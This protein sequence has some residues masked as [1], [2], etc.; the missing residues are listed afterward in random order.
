MELNTLEIAI[1]IWLATGVAFCVVHPGIRAS[2][3]DV[4]HAVTRWQIL[5]LFGV[6]YVYTALM[7]W[8]LA[9]ISLWDWDQLKNVLI[10]SVAVGLA[11]LFR[12]T[13]IGEDSPFF[14]DWLPWLYRTSVTV[15]PS[16]NDLL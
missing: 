3:K 12:L 10:W 8:G 16:A 7:V 11:S 6:V 2:L 9:V 15:G 1:L 4:L 13:S 5:L 14:H